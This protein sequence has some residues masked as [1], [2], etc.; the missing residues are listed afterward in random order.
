MF[1]FRRNDIQSRTALLAA[2]AAIALFA[3]PASAASNDYRF[4]V[5]GPIEQVGGKS[6]T[7]VRL[8]D[9]ATGRPISDAEVFRRGAIIQNKIPPYTHEQR[10]YLTPDGQGNYRL[11]TASPP[12]AGSNLKLGARVPGRGSSVQGLAEVPTAAQGVR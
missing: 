5:K 12:K 6:V 3:T 2:A 8:I 1:M 4:E 7:T 10:T 11:V 9:A